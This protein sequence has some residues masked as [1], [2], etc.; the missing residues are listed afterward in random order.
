MPTDGR[1]DRALMNATCSCRSARRAPSTRRRLVQTARYCGAATLEM[2]LDPSLGSIYFHETR[3]VAGKQP[4]ARL[5]GRDLRRRLEALPG[6]H[7]RLTRRLPTRSG[8]MESQETERARPAG[9]TTKRGTRR[10]GE[11]CA[12]A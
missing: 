11:T 5:G 7:A 3:T 12:S 6:A 2:N 10:L 8:T 1:I 9:V 4:R